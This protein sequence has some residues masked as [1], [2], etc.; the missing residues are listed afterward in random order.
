MKIFLDSVSLPETFLRD[1]RNRRQSQGEILEAAAP[2][3]GR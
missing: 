2:K 3:T 1:R